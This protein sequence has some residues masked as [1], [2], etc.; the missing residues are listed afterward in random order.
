MRFAEDVYN[1]SE[2]STVLSLYAAPAHITTTREEER[3]CA[4]TRAAE[5]EAPTVARQGRPGA[6]SAADGAAGD[7]PCQQWTK[8]IKKNQ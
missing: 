3:Q 1:K 5:T 4:A 6:A 2:S 8:K 7:C